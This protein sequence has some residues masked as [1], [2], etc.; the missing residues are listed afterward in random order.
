[1]PVSNLSALKDLREKG[2]KIT[3]L[4]AYDASFAAL[5]VNAGVDCLMI[6]DS[7]GMVVQGHRTTVP[8]RLDDMVYHSQM[9]RRGAP[10][11][12]LIADLPALSYTS[13]EQALHAATRL[14]KEGG[15]QVVKLEG[16]AKRIPLV[17]ALVREDIPVCA[18]LGLLP[19]SINKLGGYRIQ[20]RDQKTAD[21]ILQDAK[22]MDEAGVSLLVLECVPSALAKSVTES[23]SAITIGIGAGPDCDGQVLVTYDLLGLYPG[24]RPKF[25]KDFLMEGG[26]LKGAIQAY[27]NAVKQGEFPA[28][29][30]S[31]S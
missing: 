14:I 5:L 31:F 25:S 23:I 11:V 18:H 28:P 12:L 8:V 20:G 10:E 4:T 16:G 3:C 24:T 9:V 1:M 13:E 2:E 30:H 6:G 15:A 17:N 22:A 7:L 19:Q 26:S 29:E 21:E 27:V